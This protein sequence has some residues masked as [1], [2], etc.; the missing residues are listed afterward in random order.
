MGQCGRGAGTAAGLAGGP[1]LERE[2]RSTQAQG[3]RTAEEEA[4]KA[5]ALKVSKGG[6]AKGPL[7]LTSIR[8]RPR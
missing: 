7:N 8:L 4:A 6:S 2:K 5:I 3:Q 1:Y